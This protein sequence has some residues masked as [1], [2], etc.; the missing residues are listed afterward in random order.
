MRFWSNRAL[1]APQRNVFEILRARASF[2]YESE[3]PHGKAVVLNADMRNLPL[4]Q[5]KWGDIRCVI[6]SPPYLN[7]TS[8]EED[9]WL[10]LWFLG[11]P[12]SPVRNRQSKDDR[13]VRPEAYWSFIGDMWRSLGSVVGDRGHVIVRI[14]S[15]S[16]EVQEMKEMLRACA[17]VSNREVRLI[18]SR[19]T[20][21]QK[22]QTDAFRPGTSGCKVELDCHFQ[23]A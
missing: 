8:F 4:H 14:G 5:G 20:T 18:S 1:V 6:T 17:Q 23:Y 7:V 19:V 13:H 16:I 9:Q 10:R 12:E 22:R 21:L 11:G 2:R 3:R 15:R